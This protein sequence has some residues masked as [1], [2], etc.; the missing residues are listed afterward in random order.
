[1]RKIGPI[2]IL[3]M[4]VF[5]GFGAV[6]VSGEIDVQDTSSLPFSEVM[7]DES[8]GVSISVQSSG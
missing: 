7:L 6:F 4:L 3:V 5:S 8:D 1:M 2:L